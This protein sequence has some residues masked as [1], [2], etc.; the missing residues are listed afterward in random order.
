M[1]FST[2]LIIFTARNKPI[3][4]EIRITMENKVL[5]RVKETKFVG[6]IFDE[7]LSF[8]PQIQKINNKVSKAVG[9][10]NRLKNY[11]PLKVLKILYFTLVY[12]HITY[13]CAVWATN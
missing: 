2:K 6:V 11:L 4:C 5:E 12:P 8:R 10:I 1:P 9:I 13:C 3:D 7:H